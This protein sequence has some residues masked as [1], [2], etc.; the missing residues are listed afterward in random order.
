MIYILKADHP[1]HGTNVHVFGSKRE[2]NVYRRV[3]K[4]D[5]GDYQFF[6]EEYRTPATKAGWIRLMQSYAFNEDGTG[7]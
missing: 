4:E 7:V 1:L 5:C 3:L 6:I 2:M